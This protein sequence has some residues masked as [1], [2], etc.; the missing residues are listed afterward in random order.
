MK[1]DDPQAPLI[2]Q[3][4]LQ[5]ENLVGQINTVISNSE[6]LDQIKEALEET[7]Q[8]FTGELLS[9]LFVKDSY[10]LPTRKP[11]Q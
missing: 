1:P 9:C 11:V 7:Q 10:F 4:T 5:L 6:S 2:A 3:A 8:N